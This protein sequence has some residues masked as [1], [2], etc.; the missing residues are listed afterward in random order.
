[1]LSQFYSIVGPE[2]IKSLYAR[3]NMVAILVPYE[4]GHVIIGGKFPIIF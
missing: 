1:M 4:T 3:Q 2:T